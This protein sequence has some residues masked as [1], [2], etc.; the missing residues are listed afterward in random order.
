MDR[1]AHAAGR[2]F[3]GDRDGYNG[4][5]MTMNINDVKSCWIIIKL[6]PPVYSDDD[7]VI[8]CIVFLYSTIFALFLFYYFFT[9]IVTFYTFLLLFLL[10]TY[11]SLLPVLPTYLHYYCYYIIIIL[12]MP[13]FIFILSIVRTAPHRTA[14]RDHRR[15]DQR[16][17]STLRA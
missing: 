15:V 1:S 10:H 3:R 4:F 5:Y 16:W 12:F 7:V 9:T 2:D 8:F 13:L 17:S 6:L 14:A 11:H